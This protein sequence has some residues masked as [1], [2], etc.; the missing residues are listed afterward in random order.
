MYITT[1]EK[2]VG[3]QHLRSMLELP[4]NFNV[5]NSYALKIKLDATLPFKN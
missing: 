5:N 4:N 1:L 3:R 2:K